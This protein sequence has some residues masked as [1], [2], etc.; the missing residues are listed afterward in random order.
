M[1]TAEKSV[2]CENVVC[3]NVDNYFKCQ[4]GAA[5]QY[6]PVEKIL[7]RVTDPRLSSEPPLPPVVLPDLDLQ[8]FQH[9][10]HIE[11]KISAEEKPMRTHLRAPTSDNSGKEKRSASTQTQEEFPW[12]KEKKEV[13]VPLIFFGLYN[14]SL[15]GVKL[16]SQKKHSVSR[17]EAVLSAQQKQVFKIEFGKTKASMV[18]A[19]NSQLRLAK[20]EGQLV[21]YPLKGQ[22]WIKAITTKDMIVFDIGDWRIGKMSGDLRWG[23]KNTDVVVYNAKGEALLRR[24]QLIAKSESLHEGTELIISDDYGIVHADRDV[25]VKD[26]EFYLNQ[27]SRSTRML[28]SSPIATSGCLQPKGQAQ[29]CAWKCFGGQGKKCENSQNTQC[30]RFTCT[31]GGEWKLPTRVSGKE[32]RGSAVVVNSCN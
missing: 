13:S 14:A 30:V 31:M 10:N 18:M 5:P 25:L 24:D 15:D 12:L 7:D 4:Q 22:M 20:E 3:E 28:A 17:S 1:C 16:R 2:I 32:C 27:S 23:F 9:F 29:Q 8:D 6:V 11:T 21:L 19:K 26:K